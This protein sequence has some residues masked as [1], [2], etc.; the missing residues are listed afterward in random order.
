[1]RRLLLVGAILGSLLAGS[2][3]QAVEETK[4]CTVALSVHNAAT[5][6]AGT[7]TVDGPTTLTQSV[8]IGPLADHFY[9]DVQVSLTNAAGTSFRQATC[10]YR[11]TSLLEAV[12]FDQSAQGDFSEDPVAT[13]KA[14]A[15]GIGEFTGTCSVQHPDK[16]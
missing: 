15:S 16:G 13:C 9:G 5:C 10:V 4:T 1:M 11:P 2:G 12:C 14:L 6:T 7:L 3:A 8:S